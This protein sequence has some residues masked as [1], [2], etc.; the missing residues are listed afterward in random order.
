MKCHPPTID[1]NDSWQVAV[2][3]ITTNADS[4][5]VVVIARFCALER[6]LIKQVHLAATG[7]LPI[8]QA[9]EQ[10][11]EFAQ[12]AHEN[13]GAAYLLGYASVLLQVTLPEPSNDAP[14]QRWHLFGRLR[15]QHRRGDRVALSKELQA[16]E[17]LIGLLSDP[18][19]AMQALPFLVPIL[20]FCGDLPQAVRAIQFLASGP[21]TK[22]NTLVV[23]AAIN[24]LI[25]QLAVRE[26][27]AEEESTATIL[28][29]VMQLTAFERQPHEVRSRYHQT[30]AERLLVA[31]EW[32]AAEV[33]AGL[34]I[35]LQQQSSRHSAI[36]VIQA[37][38]KMRVHRLIDLAPQQ[39][40][41]NRNDVQTLLRD[42][43]SEA[44]GAAASAQFVS[45]LLD[46]EAG[47]YALAAQRLECA[48]SATKDALALAPAWLDRACFFLAAALLAEGKPENSS[49]AQ[50]LISKAL[51][52][53]QPDLESFYSVHE[54]LK[55]VDR[56]L[57]LR[58]LDR[59]D[60]G[61][62]SSPDQLLFVALEYLS[63]GEAPPAS[64]AARRVLEVAVDLDQRLEAL[65]VVLTAHN[66]QGESD[67]ARACYAEMRE[68][69]L[70]RG[71][72]DA[73][74]RLLKTETAVG[75]ALDHVEIKMELA[76]LYEEIEGHDFERA[77]LQI[78]IAR[79]LRARKEVESLRQAHGLL[80]EISIQFPELVQEDLNALEKVL[81]L[82]DATPPSRDE[83]QRATAE[84]EAQ[85]GYRPR[86]L[87]VG[88]NERQRKHHPRL[89]ELAKDWGFDADWVMTNYTSPQKVV[90]V[91]SDRLRAGIDILLLLHWNRHETTEPVLELA[92]KHGVAGRT[93][94]YAGF[95]SLQ[96]A[97]TELLAKMT[98][99]RKD[100]TAS[101]P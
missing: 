7:D 100:K 50:Q 45:G 39:N 17:T 69:L 19:L 94:H 8:A 40:R 96:V 81:E 34:A 20:F 12:L 89:Q 70:H 59:V 77:Q 53:V 54:A 65:R 85:L 78:S 73:L 67:Q 15:A 61:R 47:L 72:F 5:G 98:Q 49:R 68:L 14:L 80:Q 83:G 75:Q 48:V 42:S 33:Q 32:D 37:M 25:A 64:M 93:V 16:P 101:R 66:M 88:G 63:L 38:A 99:S 82:N 95:T 36:A 58:F 27:C 79:S 84:L 46:Y 55:K 6:L 62:G 2:R 41:S 74:E 29:Q 97:L 30:L 28:T 76:A 35:G 18:A 22:E 52:T 11:Q 23:D 51:D 60:T 71:A 43:G 56:K 86:V 92:R 26:D 57:A 87:V 90:A 31:S 4:N 9:H 1:Q 44:P 21:E 13:Q 91:A 3:Q 24:D 10:V